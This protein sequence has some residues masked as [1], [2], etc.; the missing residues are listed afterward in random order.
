MN[1]YL[2]IMTM[3]IIMIMTIKGNPSMMD[4]IIQDIQPRTRLTAFDLD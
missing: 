3:A 1:S 4:Q 2:N